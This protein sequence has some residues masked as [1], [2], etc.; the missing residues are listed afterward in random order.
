M[1]IKQIVTVMVISLVG[2]AIALR[3]DAVRK[4]VGLPPVSAV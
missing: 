4:M 3:I 1:Q 2:V